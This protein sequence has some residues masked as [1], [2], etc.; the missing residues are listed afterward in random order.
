[1]SSEQGTR[2]RCG[3][4]YD[5]SSNSQSSNFQIKAKGTTQKLSRLESPV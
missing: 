1:M 5:I 4:I 3:K 2:L